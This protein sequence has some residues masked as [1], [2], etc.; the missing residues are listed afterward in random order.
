M[1]RIIHDNCPTNFMN[2]FSY[3]SG[4]SRNGASYNL[5][6]NRSTSHKNFQYENEF[7]K[8]K[9][10]IFIFT[11]LRLTAPRATAPIQEATVRSAA[12]HRP[13]QHILR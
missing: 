4:E 5:Y 1:F 11:N 7:F 13:A 8:K 6:I 2:K 10:K 9:T 12:G 3:V